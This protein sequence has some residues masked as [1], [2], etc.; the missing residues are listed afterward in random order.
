MP[1]HPQS[2]HA[3]GLLQSAALHHKAGRLADAEQFYQRALALE[4]AHLH[5]LRLLARLFTE[6][7][8]HDQALPLLEKALQVAP[9]DAE[10]HYRLGLV[11]DGL[12]RS[13]DALAA[14][15]R[16]RAL[17]PDHPGVLS[18]GGALLARGG[19]ADEAVEWL[20]LAAQ[21]APGSASSHNNLG[22][23]L[24]AAGRHAEACVSFTRA[25]SLKPDFAAAHN[26]AGI[27][28]QH[29]G[30]VEEAL[31]HFR[32]VLVLEPGFAAAYANLGSLQ[33]GRGQAQEARHH[34]ERA[35]ASVPDDVALRDNYCASLVAC[36]DREA[37]IGC[38]R[39]VLE[40]DPQ[41]VRARYFMSAFTGND[42]PDSMPADLVATLFDG[43][44]SM[45]D[46][47]LVE[48][49]NYEVP[50]AMLGLYQEHGAPHVEA[51]L[52]LGCGTGLCGVRFRPCVERLEGVDLS[53]RMLAKAEERGIYDHLEVV[54]LEAALAARE[55]AYDLL[56]ASDVFIYIGDLRPVF[57]AARASLK[58]GGAFLFSI[59]AGERAGYQLRPSGRF[60]H[61]PDYIRTLAAEHSY[62]IKAE[63]FLTLRLDGNKP[64]AGMLF[65][66]V[67]SA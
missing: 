66:L 37:A 27:S 2:P 9:A 14:Y 31:S 60:A 42:T 26:N 41:H 18:A 54:G 25:L 7:R 51:A 21:H 48:K 44:A 12:G 6:T 1:S 10:T 65:L 35:L 30:R 22:N 40:R 58:G 38:Y 34:F 50:A 15:R 36:G 52:D 43:Y 39:Q 20:A 53:P 28:L 8:R 49:L 13:A 45:F 4:P 16:A 19:Q 23:A 33:L 62:A 11:L 24:L 64:V 32:R 63:R 57:D 59:E 17:K 61:H 56:L 55:A 67:N 47:H 46:Q 29:L 3:A 5:G